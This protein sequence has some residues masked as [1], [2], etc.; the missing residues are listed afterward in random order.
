MKLRAG[1][2]FGRYLIIA[3]QLAEG[4]S[5]PV[6]HAV[7]EKE[8]VALK[9]LTNKDQ[10]VIQ[11]F[12]NEERLLKKANH[13]HIIRYI[14]SNV[15]ENPKSLATVYINTY[16]HEDLAKKQN[17]AV[18]LKVAEEIGS[19][20]DYLHYQHP[21]HPVIHRDIKPDNILINRQTNQCLLIDLSVAAHPQFTMVHD[22][23]FGTPP[24]M[25]PEQYTGHEVAATDQFALALVIYYFLVGK[26]APRLK[27]TK[28]PGLGSDDPSEYQA[29]LTRIQQ[30]LQNQHSLQQTE[31]QA[32]LQRYPHTAQV[33]GKAMA[34]D[35][36]QR[37]CSCGDFAQALRTGLIND[38]AEIVV[39]HHGLLLPKANP[40]R[41]GMWVGG[42]VCLAL[43]F[44]VFNQ[45][46]LESNPLLPTPPIGSQTFSE[47]LAPTLT[48]APELHNTS[49]QA[50]S[51]ATVTLAG[52]IDD[53]LQPTSTLPTG[54]SVEQAQG[55]IRL[56]R[57]EILRAK[58][59]DTSL[60]VLKNKK[61][62]I[63]DRLMLMATEPIQIQGDK[64]LWHQVQR[65][66]DGLIGWI[67]A[68][69][70]E[71]VNP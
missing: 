47:E 26:E 44:L 52:V 8:E 36:D 60:N 11:Y 24:Y 58:P 30:Q 71:V 39:A 28:Q 53:Q 34:L 13:P 20:L 56:K 40:W 14:H 6:Y 69:S 70:F 45:L 42:L 59:G 35:P 43:A 25:A 50:D 23:G 37:Y 64:R 63:T 18:A 33:L 54:P 16:P 49:Y 10:Q 27:L 38:K 7:F 29:A 32:K 4:L 68:G 62:S 3:D 21:D 2:A 51:I 46:N 31:I 66:S 17:S 61:M 15:R 5:G 9:L 12:L 55:Q 41:G 65:L 67:P 1:Q 57:T 48:L 22:R 19:A